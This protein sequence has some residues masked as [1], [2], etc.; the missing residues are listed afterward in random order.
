M[1]C[2]IEARERSGI[3]NSLALKVNMEFERGTFF[4]GRQFIHDVIMSIRCNKSVANSFASFRSVSKLLNSLMLLSTKLECCS[5]CCLGLI[6]QLGQG[7]FIEMLLN[8]AWASVI[9]SSGWE[10]FTK[11]I[12]SAEISDLLLRSLHGKQKK[13]L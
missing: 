9:I 3:T 6:T 2:R 4:T 11:R 7:L 10:Y 13:N 5:F 1:F 8:D 12:E